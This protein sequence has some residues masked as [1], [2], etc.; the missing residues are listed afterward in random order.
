MEDLLEDE[1]K[2]PYTAWKKAPTPD[3]N[4]AMLQALHPTIAGAIRTHVGESNPLLL[5]RARLMTLDGLKS[6]D[7]TRGRL[8]THLYNHLRGLKRV[9][10]QQTTILKV[11]ERVSLDRYQLDQATEGLSHTLGRE[12]T[13]EELANHTGF[14]PR[15]MAKVR[16]Y[17]PGVAEG[18]MERATEGTGALGGVAPQGSLW[19][20]MVYD[21]LDPYHK[22]VMELTLGLHG[23]RPLPNQVIASRLQKSPGAISQAKARIQKMLDEEHELGGMLG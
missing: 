15:R 2:A 9:N 20:E 21:E 13:D 8:Q 7:P 18:T 5:S 14:S 22:K 3:N 16:S 10:R 6:Y 11:P 17:R 12:P 4:A 1:Y 19:H 23:R